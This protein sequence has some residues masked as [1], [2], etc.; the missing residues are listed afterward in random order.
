VRTKVGPPGF[1]DDPGRVRRFAVAIPCAIALTLLFFALALL[2]PPAAPPPERAPVATIVLERAPP[3]PTPAPP[4]TPVPTPPPVAHV[5]LAPVPQRAA[6]RVAEHPAAAHAAPRLA[7][8]VTVPAVVAAPAAPGA[9]QALGNAPG[10]GAGA[11]NETGGGTGG[12]GNET[13]NAEQP[14]G[15]V[16]F[17]PGE[18]PKYRGTTAAET[19]RATVRFP[20]GHT[21]SADFPYPWIYPDAADTDPWS[22]RNIANPDFP[23]R[24]QLPPPGADPSRF[25]E[26]IRYIL[27]HTRPDG[28]TVL[29]D[30]PNPR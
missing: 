18:A 12:T 14:C 30:C 7:P 6:P 25:P 8:V 19:I 27:N 17:V 20:D 1:A 15:D 9:G 22:P 16:E 24:A 28:T 29:Q 23:A 13:V 5:T 10:T 21:E 26:L 4:P 3:T 2:R 11:G